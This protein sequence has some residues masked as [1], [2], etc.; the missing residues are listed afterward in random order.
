VSNQ[1][2]DPDLS[3]LAPAASENR[4]SDLL[5]TLIATDPAPIEEL[6][7]G[8]PDAVQREVVVAGQSTRRSDRLDLLL[9]RD[10]QQLAMIEAKVLADLGPR[11]LTRYDAAFPEAKA[12]FVLHLGSLPLRLT[13]GPRWRSLIWEDV[14][15]VFSRSAHP[16]VAATARAWLQQLDSLVPRVDAGTVWNDVP[17]D[18]PGFELALRARVAWLAS[19]M[20]AWCD[21]EHDL[22]NRLAAAP[23]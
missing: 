23:G 2:R 17:N 20:D 15:S 21:L 16:W 6:V 18:S 10:G 11:Q 14:L 12:R 1:P 22:D 8:L 9:L 19:R 5:A 3:F 7:G 13:A 4:W